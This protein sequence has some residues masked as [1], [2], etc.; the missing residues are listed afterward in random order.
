M[1]KRYIPIADHEFKDFPE[2]LPYC[3]CALTV[4]EC[5]ASDGRQFKVAQII[6]GDGKR[7]CLYPAGDSFARETCKV[8]F[9]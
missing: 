6:T 8:V 3:P 7:A 9:A 1:Q 5:K 2:I 4:K